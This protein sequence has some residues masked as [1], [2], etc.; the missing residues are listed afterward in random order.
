MFL[1]ALQAPVRPWDAVVIA[2]AVAPSYATLRRLSQPPLQG[3][4]HRLTIP[5]SRSLPNLNRSKKAA[6]VS[7]LQVDYDAA[8]WP[9]LARKNQTVRRVITAETI[10]TI[11]LDRAVNQRNLARAALTGTT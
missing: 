5:K 4:E 7:R 2:T 1:A 9:G 3:Q 8:D 11:V 6:K 10:C